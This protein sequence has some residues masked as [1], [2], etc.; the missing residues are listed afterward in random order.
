MVGALTMITTNHH[1]TERGLTSPPAGHRHCSGEF[2]FCATC[3]G[4]LLS[5]D[6]DLYPLT[7]SEPLSW[8]W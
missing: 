8:M 5:H 7:G 2:L 3:L 6:A 1:L 4:L